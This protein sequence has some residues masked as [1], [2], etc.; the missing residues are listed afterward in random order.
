MTPSSDYTLLDADG[1]PYRSP[2]PGRY[3]GHRRGRVYG[4]L[5]CPSAARAL[6]RGAYRTHR[7]FFADES[8]AISAGYRP[9]AVCLPERYAAWKVARDNKSQ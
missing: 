9:C 4:R 8:T 5:D 6:A 3:G 7:V 2:T 1:R